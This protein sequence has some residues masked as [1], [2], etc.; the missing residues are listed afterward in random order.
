MADPS[1]AMPAAIN[2]FVDQQGGQSSVPVFDC[3]PSGACNFHPVSP[4]AQG[5][6]VSFYG[7]GFHAATTANVQC[8]ISGKPVKVEYAGPQGTPGLD[9]INI[10]LPDPSD[11][12]WEPPYVEVHL[13]IN[14]IEANM[15]VLTLPRYF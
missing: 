15:A 8:W 1:W 13:S 6:Y 9:Q 4:S 3:T 11:E 14:G 12:V 7:T 10:L 5:S 2:T